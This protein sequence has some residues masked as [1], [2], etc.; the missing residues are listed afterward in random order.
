[1]TTTKLLTENFYST[2]VTESWWIA[3]SWDVN[4]TVA[5]PPA[6]TKWWIIVDPTSL[7]LRERMFY[8]NVVWNRIYVRWVNR[9]NPQAHLNWVTVQINDVAE[10][11]NFYADVSSTTFYVEKTWSLTVNI[12]GWPV[13]LDNVSTDVSDTALTLTNN[14][15]NYIYYKRTTNE[16][17]SNIS[18]SAALADNWIIVS[19]VICSS[20]AINLISYR[21]Y[22]LNYTSTWSVWPTW[23]TGADSTVPWP[24][25]ADWATGPTWSDWPAWPAWSISEAPTWVAQTIIDN[26]P[27]PDWWSVEI[28]GSTIKITQSNWIYTIYSETW[29]TTYDAN[30]W[31]VWYEAKT[32]TFVTPIMTYA[33]WMTVNGT[34]WLISFTWNPAYKNKEN[35]FTATNIF[36]WTS[37]F[38]GAASFPY[39]ILDPA[40][41]DFDFDNRLSDFQWITI[42]WA[43]DHVCTFKNLIS[44]IKQLFVI[45]DTW[46]TWKLDFAIW[47][48]CGTVTNTYLFEDTDWNKNYDPTVALDE[49]VYFFTIAVAST[50]AHILL[51]WKSVLHN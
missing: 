21:N 27:L 36:E 10:L 29:I 14:Q 9:L 30:W 1:M 18:S 8:Y 2:T 7:T 49:W 50:W 3:A 23:P 45:Q 15:T 25:G 44:W 19:E 6:N 5:T 17:K 41:W 42:T 4:F 33:D 26:T 32:W 43:S 40:S 16:I 47:T 34:S 39:T 51:T 28:I 12:W 20:W 35:T 22:K 48:W 24:T 13:L 46:W 38:K 31:T 37:I 11:F